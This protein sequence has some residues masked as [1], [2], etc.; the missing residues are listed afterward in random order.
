MQDDTSSIPQLPT[1]EESANPFELPPTEPVQAKTQSGKKRVTKPLMIGGVAVG[2]IAVLGGAVFFGGNIAR[3]A[4]NGTLVGASTSQTP[5]PKGPHGP[6]FGRG[7]EFTVTSVS[8]QTIT[9]KDRTGASVTITTTSSTTFRNGTQT[10]QITDIKIG[11]E[12]AVRGARASNGNIAATAVMVR[13]PDAGGKV[14]RGNGSSFTVTGPN[15]QTQ[16][17]Q[18]TAATQFMVGRTTGSLADVKPGEMVRATGTLNSDGSLTATTVHIAT[19][20]VVGKVTAINGNTLTLSTFNNGTTTVTVTSTTT[21]FNVQTKAAAKQTDIKVGDRVMV[22]AA[23]GSSAPYT[24][25]AVVIVPAGF[26][27]PGAA[28]GP[29]FGGPNGPHGPW[30]NGAPPA[31]G[32]TTAPSV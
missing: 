25:T 10:I 8:G 23:V 28:G 1:P 19:P 4:N 31:P 27:G 30:N 6:H 32:S 21:Y 26:T 15:N 16:T 14:S 9:A 13:Q 17:I 2:A 22:E 7:G 24:A 18:T 29:G 20:H 3:A 11:D 12:I 5:G